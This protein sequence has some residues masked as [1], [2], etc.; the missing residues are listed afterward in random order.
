[1]GSSCRTGAW[2]A[3]TA[4]TERPRHRS[5]ESRLGR[6]SSGRGTLDV[7]WPQTQARWPRAGTADV[8]GVSSLLLTPSPEACPSTAYLAPVCHSRARAGR[9]RWVLSGGQRPHPGVRPCH[10][11]APPPPPLGLGSFS[12]ETEVCCSCRRLR[13]PGLGDAGEWPLLGSGP[14]R[15]RRR[16]FV[17]APGPTNHS[18]TRACP[19]DLGLLPTGLGWGSPS[20]LPFPPIFQNKLEVGAAGG[21]QDWGESFL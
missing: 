17:H 1:M 6:Q 16:P 15:P 20:R 9:R 11:P 10:P 12:Q 14:P 18:A 3:L 13:P 19:R 4:R 2:G 5:A 8:K 7:T 21:G